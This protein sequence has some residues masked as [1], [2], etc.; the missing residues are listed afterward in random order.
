MATTTS[1][2]TTIDQGDDV[3]H[4][5]R[6]LMKLRVSG[7]QVLIT[8]DYQNW[9]RTMTIETE[10]HI[11]TREKKPKWRASCLPLTLPSFMFQ[12][13]ATIDASLPLF[14]I[15]NR[16]LISSF[17]WT[18]SA[19]YSKNP[20]VFVYIHKHVVV[21]GHIL[22]ESNQIEWISSTNQSF[23]RSNKP[24]RIIYRQNR[25]EENTHTYS[26]NRLIDPSVCL[27]CA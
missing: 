18:Q 26:I 14:V 17:F 20:I 12:S 23:I 1:I 22:I 5:H 16:L 9:Q 4:S 6:L 11:N 13:S 7:V 15:N 19:V 3:Q 10:Q 25:R 24:I 27:T 21:I 8:R 2:T